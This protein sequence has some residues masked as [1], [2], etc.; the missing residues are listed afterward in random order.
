MSDVFNAA[1]PGVVSGQQGGVIHSSLHDQTHNA[2]ENALEES[3]RFRQSR[4]KSMI[5]LLAIFY[6]YYGIYKHSN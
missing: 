3:C 5:V 6:Q 2:L 1:G 4:V